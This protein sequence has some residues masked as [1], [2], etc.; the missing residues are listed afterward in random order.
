MSKREAIS[1]LYNVASRMVRGTYLSELGSAS[2]KQITMRTSVVED[3]L[4]RIMDLLKDDAVAIKRAIDALS[5]ED[6]RP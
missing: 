1:S 4:D 6:S 5:A 3:H 2:E